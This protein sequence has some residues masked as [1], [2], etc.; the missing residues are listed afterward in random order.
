MQ[1]SFGKK[2]VWKLFK[3][4]ESYQF[5]VRAIDISVHKTI[6]ANIWC[7]FGT[8]DEWIYKNDLWLEIMNRF[9][10]LFVRK[11]YKIEI[12][13]KSLSIL[14]FWAMKVINWL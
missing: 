5:I 8:N 7:I 1:K 13:T 4:I 14:I 11:F 9:K 6:G 10:Q 2:K 12:F 3:C